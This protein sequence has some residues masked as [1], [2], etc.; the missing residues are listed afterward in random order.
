MMQ[1]EEDL[2]HK[3]SEVLHG[4]NNQK[5]IKTV[6]VILSRAIGLSAKSAS[7]IDRIVDVLAPYMKMNAHLIY[8]E[9]YEEERTS[10]DKPLN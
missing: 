10:P 4:H 6:A 8:E 5:I 9:E 3:I 1:E 7:S 2:Y